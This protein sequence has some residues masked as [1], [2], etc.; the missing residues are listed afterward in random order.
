LRAGPVRLRPI[1][2]TAL[3]TVLGMLPMAL[4]LGAGSEMAQPLALVIVF[5]LSL[6]TL[7]TLIVVPVLYLS[8][9]NF[10]A[11]FRKKA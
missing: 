3:T 8:L 2:M 1:L 10:G 11:K 7:V 9:D 5:G 6:S 4:G